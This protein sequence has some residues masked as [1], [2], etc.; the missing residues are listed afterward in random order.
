MRLP[1]YERNYINSWPVVIGTQSNLFEDSK[2]SDEKK[3]FIRKYLPEIIKLI[4]VFRSDEV[5]VK[6]L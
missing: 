4:N 1:K 2:T 6:C 3:E 5:R